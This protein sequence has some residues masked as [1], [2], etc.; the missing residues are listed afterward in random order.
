MKILH[1][2]LSCFY[3]DG[4]NYQENILPRQNRLD[5]HEV[6]IL[7]ST[8]TFVDNMKL[9]YIRPGSYL[10]PDGIEVTRIPYRRFLPRLL[11]K[12]IRSYPGVYNFIEQFN[13][14][15]ILFHGMPAYEL[16]TVVAYKKRHENVKLYVDSHEDRHTS[17]TNILSFYLLHRFFY[18][19]IVQKAIPQIDKIFYI[20]EECKDFILSAYGVPEDTTEFYPL[21]GIV[22]DG[23]EREEKRDRRRKELGLGP[24]DI[25]VLHSG[26]LDERKRTVELIRAF[27]AVSSTK[28]RLYLLGTI[29]DDMKKD[30]LSLM[31]SD[32]RINYL[33]W[34][35]GD[36]LLEYLCACDLYAQPG[37]QSATMQNA[38][39]A[40][41]PLMLYPHASHK[42]YL[43]GNGFY[44]K[45]I[46]DMENCLKSVSDDPGSLVAMREAS[47]KIASDILDY[48]ILAARLYR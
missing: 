28:L 39:C 20:S 31:E 29:S 16:L 43:K 14:D 42:H 19:S 27:M 40:R 23:S 4:Y 45:T 21:G 34:K 2:M 36:E 9:G 25:M 12:K 6:K 3:I 24:G 48:K 18:R 17:G 8:E 46:A 11:M 33:G 1:M 13:P 32:G 5:G 26:K 10:N 22:F 38:L 30:V 15:V 44:V 47:A 7:A 41:S 35:S 37:G